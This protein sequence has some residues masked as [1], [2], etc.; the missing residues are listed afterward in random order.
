VTPA[1]APGAAPGAVSPEVAQQ[2]ADLAA[3]IRAGDVRVAARLLREL[4]DGVGGATTRPGDTHLAE[5]VLR[6]L[7]P[8]A[9]A[10]QIIGI[11][12]PPG[13]GKSTLVDALIS[14]HRERGERVGV[15]AIDP[16]SQFSGGAVLGDRI[17]MQRHALDEGVFIRSLA[18]RGQLGGLSRVTADV[19]TVMAAMGAA[20]VLVE[21]VGV[22]QDEVDIAHLA[23]AVVV[24]LVPGLGD[25]VQALKAG[26]LE[27]ADLFVVNKSDRE[28]ADRVVADLLATFSLAAPRG[29][30]PQ[31][32]GEPQ[33]PE[34]IKTVATSASGVA[35]L[36]AALARHRERLAGGAGAARRQRQA[37]TRL[38]V[39]LLDRLRRQVQARMTGMGGLPGL[40]ALAAAVAARTL[41]PY[42]AVDQLLAGPPVDGA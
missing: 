1:P 34:I 41:D 37:A 6:A 8:A 31:A 32:S 39:L 17:R 24:V 42:T 26:L 12:G 10:A 25:D 2:A 28:G 21:T 16:S 14:H 19:V 29:R 15:V 35:E 7:Y 3:R 30:G 22:G 38:E 33:H 27:I 23:D 5:A 9:G 20:V 13:A 40:Q 18:T 36:A 11:T 4:E